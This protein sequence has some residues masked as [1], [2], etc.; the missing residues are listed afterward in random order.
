MRNLRAHGSDMCE[1]RARADLLKRHLPV[2]W[3]WLIPLCQVGPLAAQRGGSYSEF[4]I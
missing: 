2:N 4:V 3:S 1:S